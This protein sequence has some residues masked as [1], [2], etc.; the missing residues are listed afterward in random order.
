MIL[1]EEEKSEVKDEEFSEKEREKRMFETLKGR[2]G[3]I[4]GTIWTA[5]YGLLG[6]VRIFVYL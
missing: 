2:R 4:L 3:F 1:D 5:Y 6:K